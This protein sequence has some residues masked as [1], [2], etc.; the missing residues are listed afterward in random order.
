MA[1]LDFLPIIGGALSSGWN[2]IIGQ[3]QSKGLMKYQS[4]LNQQAVDV[5]NRY[6]SPIAQM[7]RLRQKFRAAGLNPNLVYGNG[8]DG[9]QSSAPNVG[10]ANRP[11][12]ADFAFAEAVSNV[13][14]E[15][16][17]ENETRIAGASEQKLLA[18]K[19]LSYA[20]YLDIMQDVAVKDE[21]FLQRVRRVEADLDSTLQSIAESKQRVNESIQRVSNLQSTANLLQEQIK[22]W[23][24]HAENEQDGVR[25]LLRARIN[26]ANS[27]ADLNRSQKRVAVTLANL[28]EKKLDYLVELIEK[29]KIDRG[30][31]AIEFELRNGMRNIGMN[32]I[33]PRDL[34]DFMLKLLQSAFK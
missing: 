13:F 7:E 4:E 1:F 33:K 20:R 11:Q 3:S 23:K 5:Q 24:S 26:Q 21:T 29:V 18:D 9:N 32:G 16:Q 14:K 8:V 15:R 2:S 34:L 19:L 10:I 17:V 27:S 22:Y 28:N 30:L 6:N 12:N 31:D 25:R